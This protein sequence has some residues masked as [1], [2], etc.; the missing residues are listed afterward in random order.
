MSAAELSQP[1]VWLGNDLTTPS[2]LEIPA[3]SS[4]LVTVDLTPAQNFPRVDD[5]ST[6]IL[7]TR[8]RY[9]QLGGEFSTATHMQIGLSLAEPDRATT[10]H[11]R[12]DNHAHAPIELKPGDVCKVMTRQGPPLSGDELMGLISNG[13]ITMGGTQGQDWWI[14]AATDG[15]PMGV[16]MFVRQPETWIPPRRT[17]VRPKGETTKD[18]RAEMTKHLQPIGPRDS[19][20]VRIS[21]THHPLYTSPQLIAFFDRQTRVADVPGVQIANSHQINAPALYGGY[22]R[23]PWPLRTELLSTR[24]E[25]NGHNP[26]LPKKAVVA[27]FYHVLNPAS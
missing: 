5:P 25:R 17:P 15:T 2:L 23:T 6:V 22:P 10:T 21:E 8:S 1:G 26:T 12:F 19:A 24:T 9:A 27:T 20:R 13:E 18:F 16:G 11:L 7:S 14:A 3:N 4:R